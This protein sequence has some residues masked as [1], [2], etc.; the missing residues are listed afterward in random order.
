LLN[1][2]EAVQAVE[3]VQKAQKRIDRTQ[4]PEST[5]FFSK[6]DRWLYYAVSDTKVCDLC[7]FFEEQQP[8]DGYPG[9]WLRGNFPYLE[10]LDVDEIAANVH[11]NCRCA[12][13]RVINLPEEE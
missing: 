1:A 9:D 13:K 2:L 6:L 10:I 11:P 12:L 7:R 8:A 4:Y 3:A 5:T